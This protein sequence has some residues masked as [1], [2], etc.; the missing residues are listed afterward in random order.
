[1]SLSDRTCRTIK[2]SGTL[3]KLSDAGG[4]QL[5]IQPN[6]SR[7]WRLAYRFSGKQKLL[8]I[9]PYPTISLLEA[10]EARDQAKKLLRQGTDPSEDKRKA[11]MEIVAAAT[12]FQD[13]ADE[14]LSQ[15]RLSQRAAATMNKLEWLL[16][17][18]RPKLGARPIADIRPADVL[19]VLREVE[20]RGRHETARR[21]RSTLGSVF[22][23]AVAT[24]RAE[25]DPTS[26]L[27]GT[28][29]RP[30]H[31]PRAAVTEPKAFG[32]LLRAID[33]FEGQPTTKAALQL[34]ALLFSRPG[35]LRGAEWS[36]FD[37]RSL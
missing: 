11:K 25:S 7:L 24:G 35:E 16:T 34:L 12:T 13:V 20:A 37:L 33:G 8:S 29:A 4:L 15:Q 1:M 26:P 14:Y 27:R 3:K 19:V 17:F 23:L 21:L 10:R 5:W 30:P 18:A 32:A 28:L 36:E 22:R 9:G 2:S 6:G 31:K